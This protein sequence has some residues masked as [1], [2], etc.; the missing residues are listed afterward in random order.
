MIGFLNDELF[1]VFPNTMRKQ[2]GVL[3]NRDLKL[4]QGTIDGVKGLLTKAAVIDYSTVGLWLE[5]DG[6]SYLPQVEYGN[7]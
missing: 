7:G 2:L 6:F 1:H 3:I 5:V 4:R